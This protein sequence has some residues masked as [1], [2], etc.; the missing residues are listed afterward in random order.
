MLDPFHDIENG[1][2]AKFEDRI[3]RIVDAHDK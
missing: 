3:K 2:S 1:I